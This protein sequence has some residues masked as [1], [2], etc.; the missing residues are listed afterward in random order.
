MPERVG[1]STPI[2]RCSRSIKEETG[3]AI[4]LNGR[5]TIR[6]DSLHPPSGLTRYLTK[7]QCPAEANPNTNE[8]S[9]LFSAT[10]PNASYRSLPKRSLFFLFSTTLTYF[11]DQDE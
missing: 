1:F 5:T 9:L 2:L 11:S 6:H 4:G 8:L 7:P 3:G 10:H